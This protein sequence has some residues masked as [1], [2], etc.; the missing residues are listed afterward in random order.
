MV[1]Q[2]GVAGVSKFK[3]FLAAALAE[4]WQ[5]AHDEMLD[6]KWAKQTPSRAKELARV[7]I[8]G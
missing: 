2:M 8:E 6:S 7:F 3:R 5:R 4:D 1:F